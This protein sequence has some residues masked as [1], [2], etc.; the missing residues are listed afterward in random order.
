[1]TLPPSATFPPSGVTTLSFPY[2]LAAP[3]Q[4]QRSMSHHWTREQVCRAGLP[5]RVALLGS[6]RQ[7]PP[8][9]HPCQ[10]SCMAC[11]ALLSCLMYL[12]PHCACWLAYIGMLVHLP[13]RPHNLRTG[14]TLLHVA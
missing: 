14:L 2:P 11:V 10:E 6:G 9:Y 7:V 3:S 8:K 12:L 5:V 13:D 4:Q 1:M